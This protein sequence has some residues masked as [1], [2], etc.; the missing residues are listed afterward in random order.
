MVFSHKE[1]HQVKRRTHKMGVKTQFI[2]QLLLWGVQE[3]FYRKK[4]KAINYI[5]LKAKTKINA[6]WR[7]RVTCW[8]LLTL[9]ALGNSKAFPRNF[10]SRTPSRLLLDFYTYGPIKDHLRPIKPP[11]AIWTHSLHLSGP[12]LHNKLNLSIQAW[13]FIWQRPTCIIRREYK[14][15]LLTTYHSWN[16]KMKDQIIKCPSMNPFPMKSC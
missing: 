13:I 7:L 3:A 1:I 5:K 2:H 9:E 15:W 6:P 4:S 16:R 11:K 14:T 10:Q 12:I 8:K